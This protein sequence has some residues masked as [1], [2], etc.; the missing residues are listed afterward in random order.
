[1]RQAPPG[2]SGTTGA[3]AGRFEARPLPYVACVSWP[4]SGH[5][6]LVR[7]L[8][9][10]FKHHFGY[11]EFYGPSVTPGSGCC[12]VFPCE[13]AGPI[14]LS[15]QHDFDRKAELPD[16]HPLVVQYRRF[17]E[18]VISEFE[19]AVAR[20]LHEDTA[21]R[22]AAFARKRARDYAAFCDKW[23]RHER[24][25]R[26]LLDYA[27]LTADP[28]ESIRRVLRLFD[29]H[30]YVPRIAGEIESLEHVPA[31]TD[32]P[33][34]LRGIANRRT[35]EVFRHYDAALFEELEATANAS[36]A[37]ERARRKARKERRAARGL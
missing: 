23:V 11:C 18:A 1:V 37:A 32:G 17:S 4:R 20:N 16:G 36:P 6:V 8:Q 27:D 3:T 24:S 22:F 25:N 9:K 26:V 7:A 35:V 21:E 14:S 30:A 13:K 10:I 12:G 19:L 5:H 15:K 2:R 33:V 28:V 29:A 31:A 34:G